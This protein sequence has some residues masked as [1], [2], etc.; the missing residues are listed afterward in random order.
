MRKFMTLLNMEINRVAKFFFIAIAVYLGITNIYTFSV[1]KIGMND[2]M[3]SAKENHQ[4]LDAYI[5]TRVSNGEIDIHQIYSI[6]NVIIGGLVFLLIFVGLYAFFIWYRDWFGSNKT[7][8]VL[9]RLPV[10]RIK[11]Y[12]A[13]FVTIFLMGAAV[14]SSYIMT[15]IFSYYIKKSIIHKLL[16]T[17]DSLADEI[18]GIINQT[19]Y[20]KIT[21]ILSCLA[22]IC[23]IFFIVMIERSFKIKGIMLSIAVIILYLLPF[24]FALRNEHLYVGEKIL[25]VNIIQGIFIILSI[26]FSKYLLNKK[27]TV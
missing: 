26:V 11:V 2:I 4:T 25:F 22:V 1:C 7:I 6:R 14:L 21:I 17:D 12:A 19:N 13:K 18:N 3:M 16:F 27:I 9:L 10:D 24:V 15:T 5:K 23:I 8:Y 20:L